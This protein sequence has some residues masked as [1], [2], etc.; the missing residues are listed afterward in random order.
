MKVYI[1]SVVYRY[2]E[3]DGPGFIAGV[4]LSE[5][6]ANET[7]DKYRERA[8]HDLDPLNRH[9]EDVDNWYDIYIE[10]FDVE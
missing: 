2:P 4:Y 1:T 7:K 3:D 8:R 5:T 10:E 6:K 9:P